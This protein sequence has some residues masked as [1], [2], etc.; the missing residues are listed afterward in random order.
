MSDLLPTGLSPQTRAALD[1]AVTE[2]VERRRTRLDDAIAA[3]L[4]HLPVLLRGPIRRALG[5]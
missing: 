5:I 1:A 4:K 2:A 3:S